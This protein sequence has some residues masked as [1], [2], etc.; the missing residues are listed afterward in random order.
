MTTTPASKV[1]HAVISRTTI[2]LL[3]GFLIGVVVGEEVNSSLS[4]VVLLAGI[5]GGAAFV[6]LDLV[7]YYQKRQFQ[8]KEREQTE[9]RLERHVHCNCSGTTDDTIPDLEGAREELLKELRQTAAI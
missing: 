3:S 7:S 8:A 4:P 9:N 1:E 6:A 2:L 5:A